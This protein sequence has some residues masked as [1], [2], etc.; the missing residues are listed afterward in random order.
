[1]ATEPPSSCPYG[2]GDFAVGT[3]LGIKTSMGESIAES[4]VLAFDAELGCL[5]LKEPGA[6]NGVSTIRMLMV[7]ALLR[8]GCP[9][10]VTLSMRCVRGA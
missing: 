8:S 10:T 5:L 2:A 1:M 4:T 9:E 6:H 7:S 3:V